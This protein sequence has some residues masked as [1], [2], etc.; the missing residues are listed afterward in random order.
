LKLSALPGNL[1][2]PNMGKCKV[3]YWL[4]RMLHKWLN[5]PLRS[6]LTTKFE[7]ITKVVPFEAPDLIVSIV[8]ASASEPI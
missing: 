7:L 3:N 5:D 8:S 6:R 1:R 2:S 4:L